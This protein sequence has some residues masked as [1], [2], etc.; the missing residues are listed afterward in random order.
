MEKYPF[1]N[2]PLQD[3]YVSKKYAKALIIKFLKRER[4]FKEL[5]AECI[6]YHP[7]LSTPKDVLDNMV[8]G[9]P[10]LCQCLLPSRI[11]SWYGAELYYH[12][13]KIDDYW[14]YL[15][16]KWDKLVGTYVKVSNV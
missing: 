7:F 11:F 9:T 3:G 2:I 10:Y 4:I 8:K 16:S 1:D 12:Q 14:L 5:I 15:K 13:G 6:S